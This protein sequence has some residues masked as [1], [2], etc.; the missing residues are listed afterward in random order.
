MDADTTFTYSTTGSLLTVNSIAVSSTA[1]STSTTT[2]AL[3][4]AGGIGVRGH[5][6]SPDGNQ[7]QNGLLYTPQV[8][9]TNTGIP[10]ANA[11]VGD[12]WID[13]VLAAQMQYIKDG[14]STFWIQ[15]TSI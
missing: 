8:T 11:L 7:N 13:T 5:I 9:V 4:V 6:Y 15:I 3:T 14:T 10:P 12:F 2:G 1:N